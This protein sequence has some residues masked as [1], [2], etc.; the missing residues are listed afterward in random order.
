MRIVS[1]FYDYYDSLGSYDKEDTSYY[2]VKKEISRNTGE[3]TSK[4]EA[5]YRHRYRRYTSNYRLDEYEFF[6]VLF[7]GYFYK[8]IKYNEKFFYNPQKF[9]EEYETLA[10]K[11]CVESYL[12]STTYYED[13]NGDRRYMTEK[14]LVF[15]KLNHQKR[16]P[17]FDASKYNSPVC[18]YPDYQ[19]IDSAKRHHDVIILDACLKEI[20]FF[21]CVSVQETYQEIERWLCNQAPEHK[22]IPEISDKVMAEIKGFDKY[23]FRKDKSK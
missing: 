14:E 5:Y 4:M 12:D 1:N 23:S 7:C 17:K 3:D 18:F 8:G 16:I 21:R 19:R 2:R 10:N 9:T 6:T 20:E 22:P 15:D 13:H 11:K